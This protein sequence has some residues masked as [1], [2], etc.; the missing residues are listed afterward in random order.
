MNEKSYIP[1]VKLDIPKELKPVEKANM[2]DFMPDEKQIPMVVKETPG[3]Q[4]IFQKL[5]LWLLS[6]NKTKIL[7]YLVVALRQIVY[8]FDVYTVDD[9]GNWV[10]DESKQI[11]NVEWASAIA[12]GG[13]LITFAL[14]YFFNNP[15]ED[16]TGKT[17]IQWLQLLLN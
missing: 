12:K 14:A 11:K 17:V 7:A 8:P 3:K 4:T 13:S 15:V 16:F 1:K 2:E 6:R 10:I 9:K 5:I